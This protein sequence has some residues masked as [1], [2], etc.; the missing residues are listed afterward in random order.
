MMDPPTGSRVAR[1]RKRTQTPEQKQ[2]RSAKDMELRMAKKNNTY[3]PKPRSKVK[4][5]VLERLFSHATAVLNGQNASTVSPIPAY[6]IVDLKNMIERLKSV[7]H[8]N[9]A[10]NPEQHDSS[11]SSTDIADIDA[12]SPVDT[13]PGAVSIT[14]DQ[15][16][17]TAD[18]NDNGKIIKI[19]PET[20]HADISSASTSCPI[21]S[22]FSFFMDSITT[23]TTSVNVIV[24]DVELEQAGADHVGRDLDIDKHILLYMN[25][26]RELKG[27]YNP[28]LRKFGIHLNIQHLLIGFEKIML[29]DGSTSMRC[30]PCIRAQQPKSVVFGQ[31]RSIADLAHHLQ[32]VHGEDLNAWFLGLSEE[33]LDEAYIFVVSTD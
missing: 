20:F 18:V 28:E 15:E 26:L 11:R 29:T 5:P 16:L 9:D 14:D 3:V 30:W 21:T 8:G 7:Y 25:L 19:N 4:I 24:K 22:D 31:E 32:E 27:R 23:L 2:L 1:K 12:P 10:R 6:S 13:C 33:K 17:H